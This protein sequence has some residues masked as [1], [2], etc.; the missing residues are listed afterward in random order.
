[1]TKGGNSTYAM[2]QPSENVKWCLQKGIALDLKQLPTTAIFLHYK[3]LV[4]W[5]V[6]EGDGVHQ[7]M[8]DTNPN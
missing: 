1:M 7:F 5:K 8:K 2:T 6:G 4:F 3:H